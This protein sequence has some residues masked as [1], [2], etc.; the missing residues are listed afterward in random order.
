MEVQKPT[1]VS[2]FLTR[3]MPEVKAQVKI[4]QADFTQSAAVVFIVVVLI[5]LAYFLIKKTL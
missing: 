2:N 5:M 1:K 4:N 3:L